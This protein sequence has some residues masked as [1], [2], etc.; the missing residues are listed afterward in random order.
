V[1][2]HWAEGCVGLRIGVDI[3]KKMEMDAVSFSET[4][5]HQSDYMV[6]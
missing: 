2:I 3:A 4:L 5:I 1:G 6:L